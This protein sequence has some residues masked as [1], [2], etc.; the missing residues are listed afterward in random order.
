MKALYTPGQQI[1]TKIVAISSDS[2]FL[3][4]GLKSEG[5]LAKS[6]VTKEDGTLTV[7]EGDSITVYFLAER[8]DELHFTT[9]LS[10]KDAS[11]DVLE[12][13]Y[14]N[15]IPVEGH[16]TQEIKGGFEV[17]IGQTRAFCPYS[18]MGYRNRK[19]PKEYVGTHL[20]F[21]IQEYKNEGKNIVLSNRVLLEEEANA[22]R[23][24]R[25]QEL[26]VG[27]TVTGTV[28][29]I[30]SYG[31][32][33]DINGFQ[34]L[35]PISE[36]S[37]ARVN[38]VHDV[39]TVG[40]HITAQIIKA[41]WAHEKVSLSTKILEADPWEG[42][43]KQ[44]PVGSKIEGKISRVT[45]FGLFINM[46]PGIDG[47]VHVSKLKQDRNTNLKKVYKAGTPFSATVEKID[48]SEKRIALAPV[49]STQEEDN[50]AEYLSRQKNDGET[51][52]PFAALLKKK[53][54]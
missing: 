8:Q 11:K 12:N 9:R 52:N 6:E 20:S 24:K 49:V 38:D 27:T 45:D 4:I 40:Q 13:A 23:D 36:I 14:N 48:I 34:A 25:A 3:D 53:K 32:F 7:K 22:A 26:T 46:A 51:Y 2:V 17:M 15:H 29:S 1:T 41:D 50:A 39:L 33:I 30:E 35:L 44:F 5:I 10:G 28:Q 16:V 54:E 37:H 31:A 42:I 43:E 19:E 47:L 21:R 18:Q